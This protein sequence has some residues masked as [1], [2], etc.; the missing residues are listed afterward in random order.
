MEQKT[1]NRKQQKRNTGHGARGFSMIELLVAVTALLSVISGYLVVAAQGISALRVAREDVTAYFLAQEGLER[2]RAIR[3]T[4]R[5]RGISWDTTFGT[6]IPPPASAKCAIGP[7]NAGTCAGGVSGTSDLCV[8]VCPSGTCPVLRQ[9]V[10]TG[11]YNYVASNPATL[12]TREVWMERAAS[13]L[14]PSPSMDQNELLVRSKVSWPT[15]A[16]AKSVVL[17]MEIYDW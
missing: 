1:E 13:T 4:N 3:D 9:S 8:S 10:T 12:Y 2:V 17:Q 5:L 14:P 6:C 15:R 11:I 16:G 7:T